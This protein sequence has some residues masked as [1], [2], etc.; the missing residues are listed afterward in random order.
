MRD[1]RGASSASGAIKQVHMKPAMQQLVHESS[2]V[3]TPLPRLSAVGGEAQRY[4]GS[5][6]TTIPCL[7]I[8]NMWF[9]LSE[10]ITM[11][12]QTTKRSQMMALWRSWTT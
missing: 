6:K 11:R 9:W 2:I 10:L 12:L 7:T 4:A 1:P 5:P 3:D 8:G